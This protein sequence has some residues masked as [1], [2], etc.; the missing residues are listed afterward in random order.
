MI[1][2]IVFDMGQVLLQ[3]SAGLF[4]E[5]L[6]LSVEDAELIRR[7]VLATTEWVRMDRGTISDD[8]ALERM[9]ARLP[10]RLHDTAAYLVHRW[11]DPIIPVPGMA[12]LACDLKNAGMRGIIFHGDAAR[13][14][15]QLTELGIL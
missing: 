7:E 1:R 6:H 9:C 4:A 12:A 11:N 13:L 8:D 2:H 10:R 14:R 5:R 3:F 15:R